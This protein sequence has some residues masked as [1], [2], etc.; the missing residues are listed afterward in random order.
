MARFKTEGKIRAIGASIK[1]PN[2]TQDTADLCHQYIDTGKIDALQL[3]YSIF[4]QSNDQIFEQ[5]RQAGVGIIARTVLESGFLT[6]KYDGR[7]S[8]PEGDH[9]ARWAPDQIQRFKEATDRIASQFLHPP[10]ETLAQLAI[11]FSPAPPEVTTLIQ[12]ART[13]SQVESNLA[14]ENLPELDS[15]TLRDLD[16]MFAGFEEV[17]NV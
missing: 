10:F 12:G 9:R 16:E 15:E 8:F 14:A 6:G 5:A 4:R 11:K 3:I 17:V 2:V 1:G 13:S 7:S